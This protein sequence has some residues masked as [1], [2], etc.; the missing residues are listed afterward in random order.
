MGDSEGGLGECGGGEVLGRPEQWGPSEQGPEG[1]Q[2]SSVLRPS[3]Q[4]LSWCRVPPRSVPAQGLPTE[5]L[6][7]LGSAAEATGTAVTPVP[8]TGA[9][10]G[11]S[12]GRELDV[13]GPGPGL[14]PAPGW[15]V[16]LT[17]R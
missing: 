14:Y 17:W 1:C 5:A 6:G 7:P 4:Q 9:L 10:D 15:G 16:A 11:Q 12:R 3:L 13:A 2:V 8:T